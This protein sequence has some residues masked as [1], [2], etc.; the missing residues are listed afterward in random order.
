MVLKNGYGLHYGKI[1]RI[2]CLVQ[3]EG[4]STAVIGRD[5]M[6]DLE[7]LGYVLPGER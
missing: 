6:R 7:D 5:M 3:I 2:R 4:K 1:R